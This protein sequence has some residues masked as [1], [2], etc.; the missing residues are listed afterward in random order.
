M[1]LLNILYAYVDSGVQVQKQRHWAPDAILVMAFGSSYHDVEGTW[2][3]GLYSVYEAGLGTVVFQLG[4]QCKQ[5]SCD[6]L[7]LQKQVPRKSHVCLTLG[8][9]AVVRTFTI[10]SQSK[11]ANKAVTLSHLIFNHIW[12]W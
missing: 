9:Y 3:L 10:G 1:D 5:Q 2:S 12:S 11:A 6:Q 4:R 8:K 7:P